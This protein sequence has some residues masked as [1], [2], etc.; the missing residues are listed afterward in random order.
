VTRDTP[1]LKQSNERV[2]LSFKRHESR[3]AA[4]ILCIT[5]TIV[6]MPM[7]FGSTLTLLTSFF[8]GSHVIFTG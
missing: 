2:S 4:V 5:A 6:T 3:G 1:G 7:V 8:S